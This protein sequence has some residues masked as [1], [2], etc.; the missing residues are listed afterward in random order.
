M[1]ICYWEY[2]GKTKHTRISLFIGS[3]E[4]EIIG[5]PASAIQTHLFLWQP[6]PYLL[7]ICFQYVWTQGFNLHIRKPSAIGS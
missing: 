5:R 6:S 1:Y 4:R 7:F 3:R 2:T